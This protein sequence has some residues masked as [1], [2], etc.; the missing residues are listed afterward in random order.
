MENLLS[1]RHYAPHHDLLSRQRTPG[2]MH[3]YWA[4]G[5]A[6]NMSPCHGEDHRFESGRARQVSGANVASTLEVLAGFSQ[7]IRE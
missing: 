4:R 7:E 2:T 1:Y 3:A 6:V 5:V